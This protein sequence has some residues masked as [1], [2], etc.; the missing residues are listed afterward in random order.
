MHGGMCAVPMCIYIK[1]LTL[2]NALMS[3]VLHVVCGG[4]Q[5]RRRSN[6]VNEWCPV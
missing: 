6:G 5:C 1:V 2:V 3:V 4:A